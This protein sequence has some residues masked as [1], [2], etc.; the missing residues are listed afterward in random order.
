V[1]VSGQ[2]FKEDSI[3]GMGINDRSAMVAYPFLNNIEPI[4]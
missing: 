4:Q 3:H 1:I 2:I